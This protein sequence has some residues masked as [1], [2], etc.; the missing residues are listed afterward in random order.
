[1]LN[2]RNPHK[3]ASWVWQLTLTIPAL[4][5]AD[6]WASLAS[7][8]LFGECQAGKRPYFSKCGTIPKGGPRF[9]TYTQTTCAQIHTQVPPW[10][11]TD[12]MV[13]RYTH[14]D[15]R[16]S[17]LLSTQVRMNPVPLADMCYFTIGKYEERPVCPFNRCSRN[18]RL[19]G[20]L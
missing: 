13:H 14:K 16:D 10:S 18:P 5:W 4:R 19:P 20:L 3:V 11:D 2:P 8:S 17:N 9:H 7:R 1:M 6:P 15:L 12:N